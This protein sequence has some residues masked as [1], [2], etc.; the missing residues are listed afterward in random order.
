MTSFPQ[1]ASLPLELQREVWQASLDE[2]PEPGVH[3]FRTEDPNNGDPA[4]ITID[5]SW[6]TLMHVCRESRRMA[7]RQLKFRHVD[8]AGA[9]LD[10]YRDFDPELDAIYISSRDWPSFF[11]SDSLAAWRRPPASVRHLALDARMLGSGLDGA[12]TFIHCLGALSG[13]RTVSV[14]FSEEGWVPRDHVPSGDLPYM[15]VDCAPGAVV[16]H[17]PPGRVKRQD[18]DPW[19]IAK[20]FRKDI[21]GYVHGQGSVAEIH[22]WDRAPYDNE[23]GEFLFD[24][25][26]RRIVPRREAARPGFEGEGMVCEV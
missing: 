22:N 20:T 13:L 14:V 19:E 16:W 18:M 11:C 24:V 21:T 1:F 26:P 5:L 25:I 23:T 12:I 8:G 4:S 15:L 7:R 2:A 10:P 6:N 17:A 3:I 9:C